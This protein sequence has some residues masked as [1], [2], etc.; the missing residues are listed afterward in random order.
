M[1]G[2][3]G[4]ATRVRV[5][6]GVY[7]CRMTA[8]RAAACFLLVSAAAALPGC[9]KRTIHVTTEPPGAL[10]WLNDVEVGRTPLETDFTYYGVY[11]V[12]IRKE[13]FEPVATT[14]RAAM[15]VYEWPV[16]DLAAEAWPQTIETNIR[17]H[18]ELSPTPERTDPDAA[19]R[20]AVER[21]KG[22]RDAAA[23]VP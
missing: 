2:A 22:M 9:L 19:R 20:D 17:W 10:V 8:P 5:A 18:F 6:G 21:A 14:R 11:S 1:S 12:R 4:R 13:G 3:D 16:V 7:T 15:P 23:R